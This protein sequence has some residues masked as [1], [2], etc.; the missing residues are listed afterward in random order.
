[1]KLRC[2]KKI[3]LQNEELARSRIL[4]RL[5]HYCARYYTGI[6]F[7]INVGVLLLT[8]IAVRLA[9]GTEVVSLGSRGQ[10]TVGGSVFA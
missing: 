9:S 10:C 3:N 6:L 8:D 4:T 5:A 7:V 1:M 2:I